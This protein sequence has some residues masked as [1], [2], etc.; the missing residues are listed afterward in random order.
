MNK[1]FDQWSGIKKETHQNEKI[2]YFHPREIWFIR[3]GQNVGF[4]QDGKGKESLRPVVVLKKFNIWAVPL[5]TKMKQGK[6]YFPIG[7]SGGK[8]AMAIISQVRLT[9]AKRLKYKLGEIEK[10]RIFKTKKNHCRDI[11]LKR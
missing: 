6:Y 2:L 4:E 11:T 10:K 1:N 3:L 7:N 8:K 5:T 9:D